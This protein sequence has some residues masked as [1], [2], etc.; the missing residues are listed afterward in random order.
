MC[1]E[2]KSTHDPKLTTSSVNHCGLGMHGCQC[3][4]LSCLY[5]SCDSWWC[6]QDGFSFEQSILPAYPKPNALLKRITPF[7]SSNK[8]LLNAFPRDAICVLV[9]HITQTAKKYH[10]ILIF[11]PTGFIITSALKKNYIIGVVL[12]LLCKC[13]YMGIIYQHT[14]VSAVG[15][16]NSVLKIQ[17]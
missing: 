16:D 2:K 9:T 3:K 10:F 13:V 15:L 6:Q 5:W 14:N 11:S 17:Q 4:W 1:G 8:T 7:Y 12:I